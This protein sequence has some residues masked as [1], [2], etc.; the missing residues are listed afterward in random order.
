MPNGGFE[1]VHTGPHNEGI[2]QSR[3]PTEL[4]R[5]HLELVNA[6]EEAAVLKK[7]VI[8]LRTKCRSYEDENARLRTQLA[9][10]RERL[11]FYKDQLTQGGSDGNRF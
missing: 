6:K 2:W 11:Q 5:K 4:E 3:Q 7:Q 1:F 10:V 9:S 8:R